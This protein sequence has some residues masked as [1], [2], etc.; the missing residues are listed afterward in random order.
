MM[1]SNSDEAWRRSLEPAVAAALAALGDS[2]PDALFRYRRRP[3]GSESIQYM[4][5]GCEEL[6]G[7]PREVAEADVVALWRQIEPDDLAATRASVDDSAVS[8]AHWRHGFRFRTPQGQRKW[9]HGSGKP[10]RLADGSV[11]WTTVIADLTEQRA[12]ERLL[13][14]SEARLRALLERIDSIAVQGYDR[15]RRVFLWNRASE[16][17][18]G[19]RAEEA[20]G[21]RL[22]D[23]IIPPPMREQVVADVDGWLAGGRPIPSAELCLQDK[24]GRPVEVYS[25]HAR[26]EN[27]DGVAEMFCID[28]DVGERNRA[29]AA[30]RESEARLS[31]VLEVTGEGIWDLDIA[32][33]EVHTN[34]RWWRLLGYEPMQSSHALALFEQHIHPADREWVLGRVDRCLHGEEDYHCEFR[35]LRVDGSEIWVED[36]GKVVERAAD[37]SARRMV[38]SM[39][40]I[41]ARKQAEQRA[42]F[43]AYFDPLT[44]LPNRQ[45]LEERLARAL[46]QA[47]DGGRFGALLML[48]LDDFKAINDSLGHAQGDQLLQHVAQR[49][50]ALLSGGDTVARQGGDEFL[51]LLPALAESVEAAAAAAQQLA[52]ALRGA[53]EEPITV[54]G[55][56]HAAGA[57][58][59]I[60]LF[61]LHG[62]SAGDVLREADTALHDAK[63]QGRGQ[64]RLFDAAMR[65]AVD[66]RIQLDLALRE[67][68]R[69]GELRLHAQSEVDAR[70]EVVGAELLLRWQHP[71]RGLLGPGEF[72]AAAE[73][74]GA[75]LAI[76]DWV[77]A[78]GCAAAVRL[79][80]AGNPL[81]LSL[82]VSPRQF[83]QPDFVP[84]L[85]DL[86]AAT[87]ADPRQLILEVTEN[88][89]ID[90]VAQAA[91]RMRELAELGIRF[92]ID[93]FGTGFSSLAYL[94]R[95]PLYQLKIDRGFIQDTPQDANDCAIVRLIISMAGSLGLTVVAEGVENREQ[96]AFLRGSGCDLQQGYFYARPQ[97]LDDWLRARGVE[98]V[99]GHRAQGAAAG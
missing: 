61:P 27:L 57:C 43:L 98:D 90:D 33:G 2:L 42:Q 66:A 8:L 78:E 49:L 97:P 5:R 35:L 59:G 69:R 62:A 79:A 63:S 60:S 84:R 3:D 95:L 65:G 72:I 25:S 34:A 1:D 68:V 30:L 96:V 26:L 20:I 76:G 91:A 16:R 21:R 7:V 53:L 74:S 39:S 45:L 13:Q 92:A 36:R 88:L 83:R 48:D 29:I 58:I 23:L 28:I 12:A 44:A 54:H 10:A 15:E 94:K 85:R 77:L 47:R 50:G 38:G 4:N 31:Q 17:L 24:A 67:A 82:N 41:T 37:G 99:A 40:D 52:E 89:L 73:R 87:A 56:A 75:I 55:Q 6:F 32:S 9:L 93:D 64:I 11:L 46:D 80:R 51:L 22:E 14:L 70:G 81:P 18:Y 71:T 86:L 19:W